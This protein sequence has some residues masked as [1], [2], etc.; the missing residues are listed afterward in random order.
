MCT[1]MDRSRT[2]NTYTNPH[3]PLPFYPIVMMREDDDEMATWRGRLQGHVVSPYLLLTGLMARVSLA[4][5]EAYEQVT[6]ARVASRTQ[7]G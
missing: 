3:R 6:T 4:S 2:N 5:V 7:A 1:A